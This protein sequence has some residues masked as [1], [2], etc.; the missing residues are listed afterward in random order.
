MKTFLNNLLYGGLKKENL[1]DI[2]EAISSHNRH[3]ALTFS[4]VTAIYLF[5]MVLVQFSK[6]HHFTGLCLL[7][8]FY[9]IIF[10]IVSFLLGIIPK[11]SKESIMPLTYLFMICL[12][13]ALIRIS[14]MRV[15]RLAIS[16]IIILVALPS[17]FSDVPWRLMVLTLGAS[18]SYMI[19]AY[20][21]K[22]HQIA[23]ID[24]WNILMFTFISMAMTYYLMY[25]RFR[26]YLENV[27]ISFYGENDVLTHIKNRNKYET[28]VIMLEDDPPEVVTCIYIDADGLHTINNEYGHDERDRMLQ[29]ISDSLRAHFTGGHIYRLGGDEF[30]ILLLNNETELYETMMKEIQNDLNQHHWHIS[31]GMKST[32]NCSS[33]KALV[34]DAEVLMYHHKRMYYRTHTKLKQTVRL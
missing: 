20:F 31:Y 10:L 6:M 13:V 33:I 4:L 12:Y 16:F 25:I 9:L 23:S 21:F 17:L 27:R 28:D 5:I 2:K 8:L 34:K 30:L 24:F 26:S 18:L 19:S 11:Y 14:M 22:D 15:N 29:S 3:A 32:E 7:Y 1:Q